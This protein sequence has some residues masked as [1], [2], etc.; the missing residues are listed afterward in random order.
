ML[1]R[2]HCRITP[3]AWLV[4]NLNHCLWIEQAAKLLLETDLTCEQVWYDC[5]FPTPSLFYR[6]FKEHYRKA[7]AEFKKENEKNP[8][9]YLKYSVLLIHLHG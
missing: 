9:Q 1:R 5:G 2:N 6:L 8:K 7:P 4:N 3:Q